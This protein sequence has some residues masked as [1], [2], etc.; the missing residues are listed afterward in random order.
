MEGE[1]T[2]VQTQLQQEVFIEGVNTTI[3]SRVYEVLKQ[4]KGVAG[5]KITVVRYNDGTMKV[6]TGHGKD[7]TNHFFQ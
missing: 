1:R 4:F 5:N 2:A 6:F 3:P 7:V